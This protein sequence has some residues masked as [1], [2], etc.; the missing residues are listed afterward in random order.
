M[1]CEVSIPKGIYKVYIFVYYFKY[2]LLL[3]KNEID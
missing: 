2:E 3:I 1:N